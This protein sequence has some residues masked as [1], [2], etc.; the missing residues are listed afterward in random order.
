MANS[1]PHEHLQTHQSLSLNALPRSTVIS[2][3]L[4]VLPTICASRGSGCGI[5][6]SEVAKCAPPSVLRHGRSKTDQLLLREEV[7]DMLQV[8]RKAKT[9]DPG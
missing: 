1:L 6:F 4:I 9:K 8:D 7:G 3:V 2:V 5:Y